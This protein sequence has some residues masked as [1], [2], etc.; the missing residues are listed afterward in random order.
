MVASRR[1]EAEMK[2]MDSDTFCRCRI[3]KVKL[4]KS[5]V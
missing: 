5:E 4:L 3:C 1:Y 2:L